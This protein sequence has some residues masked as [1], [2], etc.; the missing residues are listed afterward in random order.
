MNKFQAYLRSMQVRLFRL[1]NKHNFCSFGK[2]VYIFPGVEISGENFMEIADNVVVLDDTVLAVHQ[3]KNSGG[4]Q[5]L[6]IGEGSNIGRRNHI[7]AL[8][9]IEIGA[10]VITASNVYISDC[11]H[12]FSDPFNPIINQSID[13]LHSINIGDGAWIGQNACIIGCNVGRNSVV[14]ANSVVL[15]DIPDY[16]VA[17]GIPAK[18]VK[19]YDIEL[20]EWIPV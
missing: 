9:R 14:G 4:D 18:V 17:V 2:S 6:R 1:L 7:F 20:G 3:S 12:K 19:R 16:S 11:T 8:R 10:G 15:Q 5:L 13:F